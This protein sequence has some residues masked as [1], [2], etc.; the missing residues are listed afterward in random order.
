MAS[1]LS[2]RPWALTQDANELRLCQFVVNIISDPPQ[3]LRPEAVQTKNGGSGFQM[4]YFGYANCP[5]PPEHFTNIDA[6]LAKFGRV[7]QS[8]VFRRLLT[9]RNDWSRK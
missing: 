8:K 6:A 3:I 7:F 1:T 4:M 9:V 2:S 5:M